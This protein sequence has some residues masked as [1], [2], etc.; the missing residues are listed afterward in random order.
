MKHSG[1]AN[2]KKFKLKLKAKSNFQ[3]GQTMISVGLELIIFT[4]IKIYKLSIS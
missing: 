2:S 3:S 4:L 1:G